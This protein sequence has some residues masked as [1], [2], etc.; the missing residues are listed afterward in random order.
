MPQVSADDSVHIADVEVHVEDAWI[1]ADSSDDPQD[2]SNIALSFFLESTT[3]VDAPSESNSSLSAIVEDMPCFSLVSAQLDWFGSMCLAACN[4]TGKA[5]FQ[6][7]VPL[8]STGL[9]TSLPV[10]SMRSCHNAVM[11]ALCCLLLQKKC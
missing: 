9:I 3:L 4:S 7:P 11:L 5:S 6:C 8:P 2:S 10:R 1:K